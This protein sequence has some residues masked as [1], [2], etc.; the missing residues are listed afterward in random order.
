MPK[1]L[2]NMTEL[3]NKNN[4]CDHKG[5]TNDKAI[6]ITKKPMTNPTQN[7]DNDCNGQI[8]CC[9]H[10]DFWMFHD[11]FLHNSQKISFSS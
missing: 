8:I 3:F 6:V 11:H 4:S 7:N 10:D 1:E 9:Y 5:E 2:K